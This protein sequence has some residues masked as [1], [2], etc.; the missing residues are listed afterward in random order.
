[1]VRYRL[2]RFHGPVCNDV[3]FVFRCRR[4]P[5]QLVESVILDSWLMRPILAR[6][7]LLHV[8][9]ACSDPQ[10][11]AL[12]ARAFRAARFF[13]A[14]SSR[15]ASASCN[16]LLNCARH[17]GRFLPRVSHMLVQMPQPWTVTFKLSVYYFFWL[18]ST[19]LDIAIDCCSQF[20]PICATKWQ[21]KRVISTYSELCCKQS[22]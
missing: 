18:W 1:M 3:L 13:P 7:S 2:P 14:S 20:S 16:A 17:A 19:A 22:V 11:K 5:Q 15:P 21:Y 12:P 6:Q 4:W 8:G 10:V 9:H